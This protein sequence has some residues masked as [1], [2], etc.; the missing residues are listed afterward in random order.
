MYGVDGLGVGVLLHHAPDRAE[1]AVHGLA[2]VLA[3]VCRDQNQATVAGP[4]QLWVGIILAHRGA[5]GV[6]AG[7]AGHPYLL[8]TLALVEQILPTR[9][10][11]CEVILTDNIHGLTIELLGPG[12]VYVVGA[13]PRLHMPHGN[14]QIEAG[15]RCSK[16][17]GRVAVHEHHVRPFLLENGLQ[18]Q[19]YVARDVE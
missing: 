9:L 8:G 6:D 3:A 19:Q 1:H 18:L 15:E 16:A 14:L 13:K 12:T 10:R 5:Q 4:L 7:V 17:C 2:K 11:R